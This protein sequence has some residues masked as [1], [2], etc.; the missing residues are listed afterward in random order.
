[1]SVTLC[2]L[3]EPEACC[4]VTECLASTRSWADVVNSA[5]NPQLKSVFF[6]FN[7]DRSWRVSKYT[8][9]KI[10]A[11]S[12]SVRF[13]FIAFWIQRMPKFRV[14]TIAHRDKTSD[15]HEV[16]PMCWIYLTLIK[17]F[18]LCQCCWKGMSSFKKH[19]VF[20]HYRRVNCYVNIV[21]N[22]WDR[23]TNECH[24]TS[25]HF[26]S[27]LSDYTRLLTPFVTD[28]MSGRMCLFR[29]NFA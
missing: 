27:F 7:H 29:I 21:K 12:L 6:L 11:L 25:A 18:A 24:S 13:R 5:I 14:H 8:R 2:R 26:E 16:N 20:G 4:D 15:I 17:W 10:T 22:N 19:L 1:V 23:T 9:Y 3:L 28:W